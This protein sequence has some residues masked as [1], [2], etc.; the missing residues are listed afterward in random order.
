MFMERQPV[1]PDLHEDMA[2]E[3]HPRVHWHVH[4]H[5]GSGYLC[6]CDR[7]APLTAA[8]RDEALADE[9]RYWQDF[10]WQ[11]ERPQDIRITGSVRRGGFTID[12]IT[13]MG[14]VR[15]VDAWSC[16]DPECYSETY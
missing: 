7:H 9:K 3:Q 10:K 16:N 13:S 15:Y 4:S 6:N 14:W 12:D 11:G 1:A 5:L 8:E 2:P